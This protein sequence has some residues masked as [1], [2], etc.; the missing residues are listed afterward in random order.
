MANNPKNTENLKP[1]SKGHDERRNLEGRGEGVKNRSTIARQ[2][3]EMAGVLPDKVFKTLKEMYPSITKQMS[4]E[5]IM[6]IVQANKAITKQDTQA[7]SALMDS[8]YGK[9]SQ[10]M[11]VSGDSENPLQIV[12]NYNLQT[13]NE[14]LPE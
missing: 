2:V 4:V 9:A 1:F 7:Y 12:T 14:P 6:T 8:T 11:K 13:G 5:E 3:L 10:S